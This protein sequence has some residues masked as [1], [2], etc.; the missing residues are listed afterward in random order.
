MRSDPTRGRSSAGASASTA[1]RQNSFPTTAA[2][3]RI[4][5]SSPGRPSSRAASSARMVG[6]T[7]IPARSPSASH[8]PSARR[9]RPE[10]T[11]IPT[12]SSTNSG[13]PSAA[14]V[15]RSR[16]STGSG[17]PPRRL[18]R[19]TSLAC[20]ESGSRWIVVALRF[21]PAQS[22][23]R[24]SSSGRAMHS[25]SIGASRV[26]STTWSRRSSSVGSAQWMSSTTTSSGRRRAVASNS[27]RTAQKISSDAA[28]PGTAPVTRA[29]RAA[30]RS[31]SS[32][33]SASLASFAIVTSASSPSAMPAAPRSISTSGQ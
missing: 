21:P 8:A 30:I 20:S 14:A 19:S 26:H 4:C 31:A 22:G 28:T 25:R 15:I 32:S 24:S 9:S 12:I 16:T 13:M 23:R 27:L 7:A 6:G 33:P 17:V 2:A 1:P 29:S 18:P 3:S 5:R 10:S 11:S